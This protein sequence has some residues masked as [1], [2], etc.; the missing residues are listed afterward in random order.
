MRM[1]RQHAENGIFGTI[2]AVLTSCG[3]LYL[4]MAALTG[5]SALVGIKEWPTKNGPIRFV[6]GVDFSFGAHGLDT[7]DDNR[8]IK[9]TQNN[10]YK[11]MKATN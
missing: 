9:P 1:E 6:T 3:L 2:F 10:E 4:I 8:G 7:I 5:C 11:V